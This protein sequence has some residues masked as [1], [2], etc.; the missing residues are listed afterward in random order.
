MGW[1]FGIIILLTVLFV[2]GSILGVVGSA[3]SSGSSQGVGTLLAVLVLGGIGFAAMTYLTDSTG[4]AIFGA[5][6]G[7][8]AA[9]FLQQNSRIT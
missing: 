4:W 9:L 7:G 2:F 6:V 1:I 5:I 8:L 3:V